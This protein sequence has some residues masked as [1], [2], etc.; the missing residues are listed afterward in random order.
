[1]EKK[2]KVLIHLKRIPMGEC[3][4][5]KAKFHRMISKLRM[6]NL[7]VIPSNQV[8]S[9]SYLPLQEFFIPPVA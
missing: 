8:Y 6:P 1:M 2:V 7:L 4:I 5:S 3:W 9:I